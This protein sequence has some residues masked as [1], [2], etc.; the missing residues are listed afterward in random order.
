[1]SFQTATNLRVLSQ[2]PLARGG[3]PAVEQLKAGRLFRKKENG[4]EKRRNEFGNWK[5]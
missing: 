3:I 5:S 2:H 4:L 1:M